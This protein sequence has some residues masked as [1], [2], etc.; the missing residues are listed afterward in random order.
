M[1]YRG[2]WASGV[3]YAANDAVTFAGTTYLAQIAN[4]AEQP[5]L[6]T[7]AWAVL[8]QEGATG[9]SGPTGPTGA[10]GTAATVTV[11][12]VT[13]GAPGTAAAVTNSGT[14]SA[15]VLNFT[16]PQGATGSGGAAGASGTDI[17]AASVY[18]SVSNSFLYYSVTSGNF[19]GGS[20]TAQVLTWVPNGCT[21]TRLM[22]YSQQLQTITVRM[23]L[24][25]PGAMSDTALVCVVSPNSSCTATGSIAVP[26][27][28]FID[29]SALGATGTPSP[30]WTALSCT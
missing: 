1:R 15:A 9:P 12:T 26:P 18:H 28:S 13:T 10:A 11:G 29:F 23:R 14:S 20:D 30:V 3:A 8:A 22:V 2:T 16:I 6:Y 4:S 27:G 17:S 24:G 19:S 7:L 21:A 5:N 25:Q